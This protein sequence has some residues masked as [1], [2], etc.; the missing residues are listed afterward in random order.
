[1]TRRA[2]ASTRSRI[3][4]D[5]ARFCPLGSSA[6]AGSS[7]PLD[8]AAAAHE[9]GFGEP[10]RNALDSVGD[11]DVALDL[12]HA[13]TRAVLTASRASEEFVLWTTPAFGYAT[14]GEAAPRVEAGETLRISLFSAGGAPFEV[15]S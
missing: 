8:R 6:L 7:L 2:I 5:A 10:S 1:M 12:A 3:A 11:R 13:A 14:L 9:L 15:E 4:S